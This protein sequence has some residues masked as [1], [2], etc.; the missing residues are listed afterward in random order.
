MRSKRVWAKVSETSHTHNFLS[1][2]LLAF[3]FL[4]FWGFFFFGFVFLFGCCCFWGVGFG[5]SPSPGAMETNTYLSADVKKEKKK[6][7]FP[8]TA[9]IQF[10]FHSGKLEQEGYKVICLL[11]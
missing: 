8:G 5:G 2:K 11:S 9:L 7:H 6:K 1:L 3:G 10:N 4:G